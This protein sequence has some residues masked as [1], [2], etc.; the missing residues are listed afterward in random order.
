MVEGTPLLREHTVKNCIKG[1][2]PFFS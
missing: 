2:N 1:S